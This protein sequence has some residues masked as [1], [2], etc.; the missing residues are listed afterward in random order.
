MMINR[1]TEVLAH[2]RAIPTL[3]GMALILANLIFQFFPSMGW[4]RESHLFLH[5]GTLLGLGGILL[6]NAL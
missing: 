3:I 4:L 2:F 1:V 5:L 6:A